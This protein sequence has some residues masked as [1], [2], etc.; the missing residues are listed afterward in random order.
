MRFYYSRQR[1]VDY[2][3]QVTYKLQVMLF[4]NSA[5]GKIKG[6]GKRAFV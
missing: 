3:I 2:I 4:V 6:K 1:K 5:V